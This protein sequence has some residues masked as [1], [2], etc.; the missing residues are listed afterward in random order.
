MADQQQAQYDTNR[1]AKEAKATVTVAGWL[2]D[3]DTPC[4]LNNTNTCNKVDLIVTFPVFLEMVVAPRALKMAH[5]QSA[6]DKI[7]GDQGMEDLIVTITPAIFTTFTS[8]KWHRLGSDSITSGL[9][10]NPFLF[11]ACDK[12]ATNFLDL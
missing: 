8:M 5:L 7:L 11:G 10:E 6:I 9:L 12:E 4:V 3:N 1:L 2:G